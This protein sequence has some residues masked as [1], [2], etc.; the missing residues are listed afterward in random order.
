MNILFPPDSVNFAIC[1]YVVEGMKQKEF[2]Y[3]KALSN[4]EI[5]E[6]SNNVEHVIFVLNTGVD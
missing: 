5:F 4:F 1:N 3:S 2:V 6:M